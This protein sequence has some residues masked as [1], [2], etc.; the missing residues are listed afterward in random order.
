MGMCKSC[1]KVFSVTEMTDGLCKNCLAPEVSEL[2]QRK[3]E[4]IEEFKKNKFKI[5][6]SIIVTSETSIDNIEKRIDFASAQC[7][8]GLNII[9]DLFT[10]VRNIVG[11]RIKSIED[12]LSEAKNT[13]L[14]ALK[15]EA[16]FAGGNAVV[17]IKIEHTY[18]NAGGA[19]M[20]SILGTG[21]IVKLKV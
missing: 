5:L 20:V 2:N 4:K 19:N 16:Y 21:T 11:G 7:V 17:G 15:E 10:G 1:G 12:P 14:E 13:I 8:Y 18:N 3:K 6:H 9:K